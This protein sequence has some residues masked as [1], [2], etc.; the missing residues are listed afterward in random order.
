MVR[1]FKTG[2]KDRTEPKEIIHKPFPQ[3]V[4]PECYDKRSS[5]FV[6]Q[7]YDY[8]VGVNQPIGTDSHDAKPGVP[9]GR[10]KTLGLYDKENDKRKS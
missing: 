6:S 9:M 1:D 8:G 7:G 2:F 10:V 4:D 3:S 5:S